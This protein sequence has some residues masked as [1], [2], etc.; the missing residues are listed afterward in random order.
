MH[1]LPHKGYGRIYVEKPEDIERVKAI[2][3]EMDEFEY[4][5]LPTD[6]I[7]LF[8]E[9]PKVVYTHK[10]DDLDMDDLTAEC[11]NRG[12]HCWVF[13]AGHDEFPQQAVKG[14]DSRRPLLS[15][16]SDNGQILSANKLS[17]RGDRND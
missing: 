3:H 17:A 1:R 12:I 10:F 11:W 7:T 4:Y 2:I 15:A 6:L 9:Y 8:S 13:D 16:A 14:L 5:Y